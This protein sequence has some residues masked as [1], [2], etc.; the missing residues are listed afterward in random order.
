MYGR[1][2]DKISGIKLAVV[3]YGI[4]AIFVILVLRLGHL[5]IASSGDYAQQAERNRIKTVPI[6]A[7]RGKIL[8]R[9]GRILV[10][11]RPSVSV[12]LLRDQTKE[13]NEHIELIAQALHMSADDIRDHLKKMA[14][15]PQYEPIVL[16]NDITPDEYSFIE[17]HANELPELEIVTEERRLYPPR[18]FLA[19]LI[20]YVGEV[21]KN[22]LN[23]PAF[24]LYEPGDIV[25]QSGVEHQYNDYLMGKDGSRRVLVNSKGKEVGRLDETPAEPG[26]PL[27]L[28]IDLDLQISAEQALDNSGFP[29]AIVAMDPRS[30]EILAMVSRPS[31]DPNDFAV[32]IT[33]KEWSQLAN[34]PNKPLMNKAIQAQL[35]PGSVFKIIMS[36]AGLQE[37]VA[38]H[39][40]VNCPGGATF[41]G[42]Y[43]HCW[44]GTEK[45]SG[46]GAVDITKGIYQSCDVFFYT[47]AERLG[48]E[49]IAK[50]ATALGLGQRTGVDLPEEVSGVMPS[51]E[52]KIKNFKQKWYAGETI[53]VGIGQG[54]IAVTPIQL[55]RAISGIAQDG[56]M[57]TPH[58][59][60]ADNPPEVTSK[61]TDKVV[62]VQIDEANWV[63]IT[64][65]MAQV[66]GPLGT[67]YASKIENVDW[68]GKTG[69]AQTV[70]NEARKILKGKQYND[71]GWFVGVSPHRNPE[72]VVAVL[73]QSGEHGPIAARVASEFIRAYVAK[74]QTRQMK[75]AGGARPK[76]IEM[77]G[78]WTEPN[79]DPGES[80]R[81]RSAKFI[82]P[83]GARPQRFHRARR[84]PGLP[85]PAAQKT[86]AVGG[87]N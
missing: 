2:D 84:A 58:V 64:D 43:F 11:N 18:G 15:S 86:V 83:L 25:G 27:K 66:V 85:P 31:F 76:T 12:L 60:A 46:H 19:H 48:I 40:V 17:A 23:Q 32:R 5:Q 36:V 26:K 41:Y 10:D 72:V 54:A 4:L 80:A 30:G 78:V 62:R 51:E 13:L 77:T 1:P 59:I 33:S 68:G 63:T 29:G 53:S 82:I 28:T 69:S 20:G 79:D 22:M 55:A 50:W 35:A 7:P 34:D 87:G 73:L 57:H 9:E 71:N 44:I 39:M 14:W 8:D 56:V 3:Q 52:W 74:Q 81:L 70:S 6:L 21:N 65:A 24:E 67:A 49:K 16:K 38:Q 42:R 47:L 45:H 37:G 61:F 75:V